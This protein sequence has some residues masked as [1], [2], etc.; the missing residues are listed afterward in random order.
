MGSALM[1]WALPC[2][3]GLHPAVVGS[4]LLPSVIPCSPDDMGVVRTAVVIV[5][6][7]CIGGVSLLWQVASAMAG[8]ASNGS[9]PQ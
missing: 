8:C 7:L 5:A 1:P 2:C 3:S 9:V 6:H 4:S